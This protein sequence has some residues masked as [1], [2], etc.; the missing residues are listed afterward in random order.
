MD[1]RKIIADYLKEARMMTVATVSSDQPWNATVYYVSDEELNLYWISKA[2]SRHS[3]EIHKNPKVAAAIPI[4]F[5]D[6]TVVGLSAEGEAEVM[7][8]ADEIKR[9]IRSYTD[10]FNRGEDW[11]KDFIAGKNIHKLYKIKPRLF[12]LFDREKFPGNER[13]ELSL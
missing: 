13:Q 2:E 6:L 5:A 7:E 9:I 4:K 3:K 10:K 8:D 1:L 11:Y 12:V